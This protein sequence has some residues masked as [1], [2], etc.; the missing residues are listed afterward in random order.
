MSYKKSSIPPP[1]RLLIS[2]ADCA[3]MLDVGETT[4]RRLIRIGSLQAVHILGCQRIKIA[5]V[6]AILNSGV[7]L[8]A[9]GRA[10]PVDFEAFWQTKVPAIISLIQ[11]HPG[12]MQDQLPNGGTPGD[13]FDPVT[14][15]AAITE[16]DI[17]RGCK[18]FMLRPASDRELLPLWRT[19]RERARARQTFE[20]WI[21]SMA[22]FYLHCLER[23][24]ANPFRPLTEI[25][26]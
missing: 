13:P 12:L 19:Y 6:E 15:D 25:T 8:A 26:L 23:G 3:V 20:S 17:L 16:E 2:V 18:E 14:Y 22:R 4:V 24:P 10:E 11:M 21:L 7:S 5:S 1:K 9:M